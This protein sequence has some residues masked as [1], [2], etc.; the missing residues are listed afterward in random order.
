MHTHVTS[1]LRLDA[2]SC[3]GAKYAKHLYPELIKPNDTVYIKQ[4]SLIR[5]FTL[6]SRMF[7]FEHHF[8]IFSQV[9]RFYFNF[10]IT[11]IILNEAIPPLC[12]GVWNK[13]RDVT[14]ML[15][16]HKIAPAFISH[17]WRLIE[18]P[19]SSMASSSRD[20]ARSITGKLPNNEPHNCG[21]PR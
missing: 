8:F 9:S 2:T 16:I 15:K 10:V 19:G 20:F 1:K 5:S 7:E 11:L 3:N 4:S 21:N 13:K 12:F 6:W 14:E 17:S 18:V